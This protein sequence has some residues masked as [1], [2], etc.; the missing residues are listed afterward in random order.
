[1]K[2]EAEI[3]VMHIQ[4][5]EHQGLPAITRS[6][7]R[8]LEQILPQILQKEPTLLTLDFSLLASRD[9]RK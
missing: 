9:L 5:K 2:T 7:E 3:E 8:G 4:A 1:M 6:Y